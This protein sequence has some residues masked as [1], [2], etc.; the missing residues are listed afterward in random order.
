MAWCILWNLA[1]RGMAV[2]ERVALKIMVWI[3]SCVA[4][5][6]F[7]KELRENFCA[8]KSIG[9][10][11]YIEAKPWTLEA[12]LCGERSCIDVAA[13]PNQLLKQLCKITMHLTTIVT[14][15]S[16]L[17]IESWAESGYSRLILAAYV[18]VVNG[19]NVVFPE[20]TQVH[21]CTYL[22]FDWLLASCKKNT[23]KT[24]NSVC[25]A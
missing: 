16:H 15:Y 6:P 21:A 4:I 10:Q 24:T 8:Q 20:T 17:F 3:I 19:L 18:V 23:L 22:D 13:L 1:K 25:A 12:V 2:A 5:Q 14:L 7:S 11:S 9:R